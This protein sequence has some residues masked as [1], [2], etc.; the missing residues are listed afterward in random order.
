MIC[1]RFARKKRCAVAWV[2]FCCNTLFL[3]TNLHYC[4]LPSFRHYSN[5]MEAL[6]S[7]YNSLV[8]G[9]LHIGNECVFA[10]KSV[11][12]RKCLTVQTHA[13][14]IQAYG[15]SFIVHLFRKSIVSRTKRL[16]VEN[17]TPLLAVVFAPHPLPHRHTYISSS[18]QSKA[19]RNDPFKE[20]VYHYHRYQGN[21]FLM[22]I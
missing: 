19:P 6:F 14:D 8:V 18:S 2:T 1:T 12:S 3:S 16:D 17:D 11:L 10:C 5:S 22:E 13:I 15:G 21:M 20:D 4:T 9:V 7:R